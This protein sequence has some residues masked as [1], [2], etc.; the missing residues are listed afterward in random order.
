METPHKLP[1]F[2]SGTS[3]RPRRR[4][5]DVEILQF[6]DEMLGIM[7]IALEDTA[8]AGILMKEIALRELC[9]PAASAAVSTPLRRNNSRFT[10][11]GSRPPRNRATA[12]SMFDMRNQQFATPP[13]TPL[14]PTP[15]FSPATFSRSVYAVASS[16]TP[17]PPHQITPPGTFSRVYN[18]PDFERL[19][20]KPCLRLIR[21]DTSVVELSRPCHCIYDEQSREW[22][23]ADKDLGIVFLNKDCFHILRSIPD[24]D[25]PSATVLLNAGNAL[26]VLDNNGIFIYDKQ[27]GEKRLIFRQPECRGLAV[28]ATG[29]F[30]TVHPKLR[31]IFIVPQ[32]G[33]API[34]FRYEPYSPYNYEGLP[35][36]ASSINVSKNRL[37]VVDYTIGAFNLYNFNP[38]TRELKILM[39]QDCSRGVALS[40][41]TG[42]FMDQKGR[43]IVSN[44][45]ERLCFLFDHDGK[46][47]QKI[48]CD[49]GFPR[50]QYLCVNKD[51]QAVVIDTLR[52]P[53]SARLYRVIADPDVLLDEFPA[54]KHPHPIYPR[55][56]PPIE[57]PTSSSESV[58]SGTSSSIPTNVL[59]PGEIEQRLGD[60]KRLITTITIDDDNETEEMI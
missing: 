58:Q 37:L 2:L 60:C 20:V 51:F 35:S 43:I 46:F 30:V 16:P 57:L 45:K 7:N 54:A 9:T 19:H 15:Q 25:G 28:T 23:V 53:H 33:D 50:T 11:Y 3:T 5:Y 48:P 27:Y 26:G 44:C 36:I 10:P 29:D 32:N 55:Q 8:R 31:Y 18:L 39:Q 13:K 22:I 52:K 6:Y 47:L 41:L 21:S 38:Y 56:P 34:Y 24:F 49:G 4:V 59:E 12:P 1:P 40:R 42:G 17:Q 14:R